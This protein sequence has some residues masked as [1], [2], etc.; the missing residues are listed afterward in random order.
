M[1]ALNVKNMQKIGI[2]FGESRDT[3]RCFDDKRNIYG[4]RWHFCEQ[5]HTQFVT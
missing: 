2:P 3:L 1:S 4:D 5:K